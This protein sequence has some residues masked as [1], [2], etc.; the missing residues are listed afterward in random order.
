MPTVNYWVF[1]EHIF[2]GTQNQ[3]EKFEAFSLNNPSDLSDDEKTEGTIPGGKSV[4][5]VQHSAAALPSLS[6][7]NTF[8]A[9]AGGR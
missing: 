3:G 8:I 2:S 7:V 6:L 1:K 5:G 4:R 9:Q